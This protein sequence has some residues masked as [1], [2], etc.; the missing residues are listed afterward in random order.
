VDFAKGNSGWENSSAMADFTSSFSADTQKSLGWK[1]MAQ[2][3][4]LREFETRA[5]SIGKYWLK[6]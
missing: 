1:K 6:S 5:Q 2:S 4:T 3:G